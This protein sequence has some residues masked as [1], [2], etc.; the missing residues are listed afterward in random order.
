MY[1]IC[2]YGSI[3]LCL[4]VWCDYMWVFV[5]ILEEI[6][7]MVENDDVDHLVDFIGSHCHLVDCCHTGVTVN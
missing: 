4:A 5:F 2:I 3:V 7:F 1:C 6:F